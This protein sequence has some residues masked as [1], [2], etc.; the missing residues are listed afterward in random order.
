VWAGEAEPPLD[1]AAQHVV[2]RAF[3]DRSLEAEYR[4]RS[5]TE[6]RR[7]FQIAVA[8]GIALWF[9]TAT[10]DPA[11]G[12]SELNTAHLRHVRLATAPLLLPV[13]AFGWSPERVFRHYWQAALAWAVGVMLLAIVVMYAAMPE[14]FVHDYQ[15]GFVGFCIVVLGG[16]TLAPIRFVYG[17]VVCV[18]ATLAFHASLMA[19]LPV[20]ASASLTWLLFSLALGGTSALILE[21]SRRRVFLFSRMLDAERMRSDRLLM[22]VLPAPI[23]ARLRVREGT[24]AE[25]F[26]S[27]TIVFADLVGFTPLA[28]RMQPAEL[29]ANLDELFRRFDALAREHGVEKIKT[30]GDA[31]MFASGVPEH[32][33]D[34]VFAATDMAL[35]MRALVGTLAPV[36][37][38]RLSLRIGIHTG[39]V[40]AGVIGEQRL[41]YDLW[42]DTVNTA[43]RMESHGLAD[44]VQVTDAVRSVLAGR[45]DLEER[46][47]I[48]V[49]GKGTMRTWLVLRRISSPPLE[50][51]PPRR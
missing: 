43:S 33:P 49:K 41:V 47:P 3:R 11:L 30:I 16:F 46:A 2:T 4:V 19:R 20:S 15:F 12:R 14:P 29:V 40:V 34:H 44:G 22:N 26:E 1:Q 42:G 23:A 17:A 36:Y 32:R 51:R 8:V 48:D 9:A 27:A 25:S 21:Q 24:I 18:P 39:P 13:I 6:N 5:S 7:H 10:I 45:Y 37:G 31:Y 35:A 28:A 50:A 38:T